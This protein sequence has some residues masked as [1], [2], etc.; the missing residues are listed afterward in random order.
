MLCIAI[1]DRK[2]ECEQLSAVIESICRD[3]D[4]LYSIKTFRN[5]EDLL[6]HTRDACPFHLI[7]SEVILEDGNGIQTALKLRKR[8]CDAYIVFLSRDARYAID[9]YLVKAYDYILK[10]A[11]RETLKKILTNLSNELQDKDKAVFTIPTKSG[12]YV[13]RRHDVLY[14]ESH[15]H[16]LILHCRNRETLS[17]AGKLDNLCLELPPETASGFLRCHKSYLVNCNYIKKVETSCFHL[18]DGT[19]VP[20]SRSYK[21]SAVTTYMSYLKV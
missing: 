19:R 20:I 5:G 7:F 6:E 3:L 15:N 12:V 16:S 10:P 14:M 21:T 17:F 18:T 8:R 13:L 9:S 4:I 2:K 1:C 11:A